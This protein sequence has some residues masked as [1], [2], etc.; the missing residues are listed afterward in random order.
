MCVTLVALGEKASG[1]R[2][3]P[4]GGEG[5]RGPFFK[6]PGSPS[7]VRC[8]CVDVAKPASLKRQVRGNARAI[9]PCVGGGASLCN[10]L[11][12]VRRAVTS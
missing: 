2:E 6:R 5:E 7:S 10:G 11:L 4:F 8:V 1:E 9:S 3:K 12:L